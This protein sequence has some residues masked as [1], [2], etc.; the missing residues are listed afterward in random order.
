MPPFVANLK[1][2]VRLAAKSRG[3]S[4][5]A[6]I[7][8][9]VTVGVNSAIFSLIDGALLQPAVPEKP[10]EVVCIFTGSRDGQRSFRQFSYAEFLALRESNSSLRLR[11]YPRKGRPLLRFDSRLSDRCGRPF[12]HLARL[13][14]AGACR[15]GSCQQ[16][17]ITRILA[18][19]VTG[20]GSAW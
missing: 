8:L 18:A 16:R 5:V 12:E 17:K 6:I 7:T 9:A 20:C 14:A 2:A 13:E 19:S 10:K 3:F 11:K 4:A 15:N 1:L